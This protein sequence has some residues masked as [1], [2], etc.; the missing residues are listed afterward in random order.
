MK[1]EYI[2][3]SIPPSLITWV[4]EGTRVGGGPSPK[5]G[6]SAC[7]HPNFLCPNHLW[8]QEFETKFQQ[9][10]GFE[11]PHHLWLYVPLKLHS[12][13]SKRIIHRS[14]HLPQFWDKK[15]K[16]TAKV[17]LM[18]HQQVWPGLQSWPLDVTR[19][20]YKMGVYQ[21]GPMH[22]GQWSH[23]TPTDRMTERH[24]WNHYLPVW[25]FEPTPHF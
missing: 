23:G 20:L 2:W 7:L 4:Q 24:D 25:W 14:H 6:A 12:Y 8:V 18:I 22:H 13:K 3:F 21:W 5:E 1:K 9:Q 10:V 11:C 19:A 15:P 17:T 16:A